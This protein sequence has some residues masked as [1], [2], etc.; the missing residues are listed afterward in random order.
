M[1][2]LLVPRPRRISFFLIFLQRTKS[3]RYGGQGAAAT[4]SGV[5]I[6][7][8]VGQSELSRISTIIA[9][10]HVFDDETR[11]EAHMPIE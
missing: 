4:S 10:M 8:T 6:D 1:F 9:S 7:A 3:C 5:R 11:H 2:I